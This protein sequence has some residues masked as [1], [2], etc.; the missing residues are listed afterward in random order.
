MIITWA[1]YA[2]F[3]IEGSSATVATDPFSPKV[4][5]KLP[6]ISAEIIISTKND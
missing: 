4:G 3:K 5:M 6:K 1:G 2:C